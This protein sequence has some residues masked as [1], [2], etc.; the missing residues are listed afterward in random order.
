MVARWTLIFA[1]HNHDLLVIYSEGSASF[2]CAARPPFS[3]IGFVKL[4]D[5]LDAGQAVFL[6]NKLCNA[7][8][9]CDA[10]WQVCLIVETDKN[11]STIVIVNNATADGDAFA[12]KAAA[13]G[14]KWVEAGWCWDCK[15]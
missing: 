15:I 11:I 9:F 1:L 6:K 12:G 3:S 13:V 14:D 7:V 4:I 8:M 5:M 10:K 2:G